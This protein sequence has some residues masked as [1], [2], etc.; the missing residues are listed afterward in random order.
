MG[1]DGSQQHGASH[2]KNA[3]I[4]LFNYWTLPVHL[5][6]LQSVLLLLVGADREWVSG[7]KEGAAAQGSTTSARVLPKP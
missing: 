2:N 7:M 4:V 3:E 5:N 6:I 1:R